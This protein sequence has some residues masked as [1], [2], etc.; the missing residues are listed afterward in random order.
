MNVRIFV[1]DQEITSLNFVVEL[2]RFKSLFFHQQ[3]LTGWNSLDLDVRNSVSLPTFKAKI[4]RFSFRMPTM[5]YMMVL[6]QGVHLLITPPLDLS[7]LV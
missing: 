5:G 2:L 3:S 4:G 6:C 7:F 1:S